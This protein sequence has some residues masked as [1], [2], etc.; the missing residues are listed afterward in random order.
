MTPLDL[1]HSGSDAIG[2]LFTGL[3]PANPQDVQS[4]SLGPVD[5]ARLMSIGE[6][7]SLVERGSVPAAFVWVDG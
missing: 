2:V 4:G 3:F 7:H 6:L 1:L 5:A